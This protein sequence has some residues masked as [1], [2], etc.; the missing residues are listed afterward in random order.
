MAWHFYAPLPCPVG[1]DGQAQSAEQTLNFGRVHFQTQHL[2]DTRSTQGDRSN[3]WQVLLVDGF[4]DWTRFTAGDVQQQACGP[5]HRFTCQFPVH[6]T[7]VTMRSI[8]VQTV[9]TRFACNSNLIEKCAFEEHIAC[10]CRYTTVFTAHDT[11]NCQ[12]A[13]VVSDHQRIATQGD[14]LAIKQNQ[15]LAFFCHAHANAT[16]D[17]GEIECVQRLTQLQ[18]HVVGDVDSSV[19]A[20]HVCTTQALNHPQRRRTGQ[21]NV[22]DDTPQITRA[23]SRCKHFNR[24]D[25]IVH[26]CNSSDHRTF[27][28]GCVKRTH[29]A[30]Q[31]RQ[32]QAVTAVRGQV[33]FNTGVFQVQIDTEILAYR[34]IGWQFHQ[35]VIAFANLQ[36]SLRAQH[37]VGL[38]A[39]QLGF[40]DFE[41]AWQFGTDHGERDLQAWA[42]IGCTAHNL[43]RLGAIADLAHAQFISV[44]VLFGA[45]HLTHDNATENTGGRRNAIDLKTG[46]RQT[47][48]QLVATYLR[49][50]P[51]TQPLFTEFHPALLRIRYD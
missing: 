4:N 22:T 37:A 51:T 31:A 19:D 35:A 10:R 18:H 24:A 33:N 15:F 43:K 1:G 39:P 29:F 7:L 47:S 45:E 36:L 44:R 49:V 32:R 40:L 5:L 42:H 20:T 8:S 14:F 6:A 50:N 17:L 28:L 16:I 26:G 21:I 48:N 12:C 41:I 27:H 9:R 34:R 46:H 13:G 25:F 11:G 38:N 23:R 3:G 30:S 2:G